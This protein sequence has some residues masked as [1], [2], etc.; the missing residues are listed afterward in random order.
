MERDQAVG[1]WQSQPDTGKRLRVSR[2]RLAERLAGG[3]R[4]GHSDALI[5]H[6]DLCARAGRAPSLDR[7]TAAAR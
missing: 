7:Y 1:E 3:V 6:T 4:L 2:A 5:A